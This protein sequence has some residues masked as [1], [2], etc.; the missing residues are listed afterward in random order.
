MKLPVVK[1]LWGMFAFPVMYPA[2]TLRAAGLPLLAIIATSLYWVTGAPASVPGM[3]WA[4]V[5]VNAALFSWLAVRIHR[6]VLLGVHEDAPAHRLKTV[7]NYLSAL[8]LGT[9]ILVVLIAI[10]SF[11]YVPTGGNPG[12]ADGMIGLPPWAAWLAQL[13]AFY[14]L[15]RLA[16]ALPAF[17][18]GQGWRLNDAWRLSSGNGWRLVLI[19]FLLPVGIDWFVAIVYGYIWY[20]VAIAALAVFKALLTTESVI[21]LSLAYREL[22]ATPE[23][24]PTTPPA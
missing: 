21:A 6:L 2:A 23:P 14:L 15:A 13:P 1:I 10:V 3:P 11:R 12:D 16:V 20:S 4:L 19:V 9:V 7:G 18:L 24:P 17:A 8:V 5:F 22:T